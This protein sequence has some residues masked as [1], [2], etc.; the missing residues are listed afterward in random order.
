MRL[1]TGIRPGPVQ[2]SEGHVVPLKP[3]KAGGGKEP[4]FR[5][6]GWETRVRGLV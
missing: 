4:W 2:E 5:V 1:T 6:R 3:V